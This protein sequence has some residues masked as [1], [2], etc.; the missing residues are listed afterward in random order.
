MA[1]RSHIPVLLSETIGLLAPQPGETILDCTAGLGGHAAALAQRIGTTGTLILFDLDAANLRAAS[2]RIRA[3]P[4][5]PRVLTFAAP[6][7]MP[8]VSS[9]VATRSPI[10]YIPHPTSPIPP[11]STSSSPISASPRH[12]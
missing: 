7:R 3:L 9:P 1:P 10:P 8:P 4:N 5:A 2:E 12:K 11:P 6:S